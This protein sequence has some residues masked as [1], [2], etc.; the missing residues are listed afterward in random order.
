[1]LRHSDLTLMLSL[2]LLKPGPLF[3]MQTEML[4][5]ALFSVHGNMPSLWGMLT[6]QHQPAGNQKKLSLNDFQWNIFFEILKFFLWGCLSYPCLLRNKHYQANKNNPGFAQWEISD[7]TIGSKCL[8]LWS[9]RKC[10]EIYLTEKT[11]GSI[12]SDLALY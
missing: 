1:M 7:L 3:T 8:L 12:T 6:F 11:N 10:S 4:A 9:S 5:L 2:F